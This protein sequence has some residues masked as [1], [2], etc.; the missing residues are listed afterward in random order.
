MFKRTKVSTGVLVAL[1]GALLA[2]SLPL[3]AQS[4]ERVE[5]TGSRILRSDLE[6][7]TPVVSIGLETMGNLGIENF[8]DMATQL[9]QFAPSFGASRTQ[10]TFS[11]VATSGLN[12]ANLRNL[13]SVR[14]LVLIN[15]RRAAGGT[16]TSTAVDFN[17]LPTANVERIEIITGGASA[18]Y[19]SDAVAGVINIITKKIDGVELNA[20]YGE[21]YRGDN[22]NP[23]ASI[24]MGGKFG[25]RGRASL[26]FEFDK[27]GQV[28]CRDREIC[29][30][31]FLWT[32]PANQLRGPA[33]YSSVGLGGRFFVGG[34]SFAGRN[35]SIL[36]ANGNL[37]PFALAIDGYN[38][39]ADRDI[40]IP[41]TRIMAAADVEYKI[42]DGV[43]A[44]GELNFGETR[45]DSKFEG[46]PFQSNQPGSRF[47]TLNPNIPLNNPFIPGPLTAAINAYNAN[48][49]LVG[50]PPAPAPQLTEI[51]WWQRFND[52]G[53]AR[54]ADSSR[55]MS[56]MVVG[57]KGD[58]PSLGGFGSNFRWE[59]SHT[60]ARTTVNLN[61]Q[62]LVNTSN[63][64]H[65]LR[66]EQ[67]PGAAAGTYRCV[68]AGARAQGCVPINPF[69]PYTDEMKRALRIGSMAIGTSSLND[70]LVTLS[71]GIADL[72]AGTL[73]AAVGAERRTFS[74][75]LDRDVVVNNALATGNQISDT[76]FAKTKTDELFA[77]VLVPVLADMPF[78]NSLNLEGAVRKSN[79][80]KSDYST[81]NFGGDWEPVRGLRLRA[82]QAKAV[83]AP[84]PGELSGVGQTFGVVQDPCTQARRN[85]NPTRAAN[86]LAD[87]VPDNY[88]PPQTVEQGVAGLTGGNPNLVPEEGETL[89][90][91]LVWTP[92]FVKGLSIAIDRF[93]MDVTKIITTV[94]RQDSVNAC[95]DT[96]NRLLCNVVV[97]GTNVQIPGATYVLTAVNEQLENAAQ[98]KIAGI[99][100]DVR[101][102][103][104]LPAGLGEMDLNLLTTLYDEATQT[105]GV[106]VVINLLG[107]AGGSTTDQGWV[108]LTANA[109]IGWKYGNFRANWNMRHIGKADMS[110]SSTA[111]GFPQIPAHTYHNLRLGYQ[112]SKNAEIYGGVTNLADKQPPFF[113]SGTSG[114]QALD[115]VPGYYDVFGRSYFVGARLKF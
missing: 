109:N 39:N 38:R 69:A 27:Q 9:P 22:Q 41:T 68:D 23:N 71:G 60:A 11:G 13:G 37:I 62:G 75:F 53:E 54:G 97:R 29:S 35:G 31:D 8:A 1:G 64:Y 12:L 57:L 3:L 56:R 17:N 104:A 100:L 46:H 101:Y 77:E 113:A 16:S 73:R 25:D 111:A 34:S 10:S 103:F 48:P 65:G 115:T 45:I 87:G 90:Y 44:F 96:P 2:T 59:L 93:E 76:D 36:D 102:N 85:L 49:P 81:Y 94:S 83:R 98:L 19:G 21:S 47:G 63:L 74:G 42:V 33:A 79:T 7:T 20:S 28:S 99:D 95:Y 106:G 43:R 108:K 18:V 88:T 91:G 50:T 32:S 84:L 40:A 52:V 4:G 70:T 89:T 51:V 24:V 14:S 92:T 112:L 80:E 114:T 72:P 5:I 26:T 58:L 55:K 6:G 66:V 86:C 61:T 30:E 78:A 107:A 105:T 82:K 15:G 110:P 67:I